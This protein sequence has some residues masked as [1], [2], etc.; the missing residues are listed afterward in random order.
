MINSPSKE[1][2][3]IILYTM[4]KYVHERRY[5]GRIDDYGR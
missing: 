1:G 3:F 4:L 5:V 2:L